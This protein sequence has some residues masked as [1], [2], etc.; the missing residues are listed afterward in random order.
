MA[1]KAVLACV[2]ATLRSVSNNNVPF[3]GKVVIL[4]GDFCQTCPVIQLG[5]KA[6]VID[7]CIQT[8]SLWALFSIW[9]LTT[10]IRNAGDPP[11]QHFVDDIGNGVAPTMSLSN[12]STVYSASHLIDF[13]FPPDVLKSPM[14]CRTHSILALTNQQINNYNLSILS[15]IN[16]PE[17]TYLA[18]DSI[19]EMENVDIPCPTSL[20]DYISRQ[21]PP[22]MPTHMLTVKIGGV[23]R[24]LRNLSVSRGL[25]KTHVWLSQNS[26]SISSLCRN[27]LRT[28]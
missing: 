21:T 22:G 15:C 26:V 25:V 16:G 12:L 13:V 4:L 11:F 3:G 20:L 9:H 5:R 27:C 23:Y 18:A 17:H 8:S 1:N 28:I 7:A 19:K 6:D 24:I 10:P 14:L 2:D